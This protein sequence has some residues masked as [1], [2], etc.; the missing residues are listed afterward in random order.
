MIS[1]NLCDFV[2]AG[3]ILPSERHVDI[4][5]KTNDGW[6]GYAN[7]W[8]LGTRH[9]EGLSVFW[10]SNLQNHVHDNAAVGGFAGLWAFTHSSSD[11]YSWD[12][13]PINPGLYSKS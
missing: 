7:K 5:L 1:K 12:A 4:C 2:K 13:I 8:E 11:K 10:I 6:P 3:I 9:C